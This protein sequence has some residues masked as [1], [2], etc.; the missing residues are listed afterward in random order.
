MYSLSWILNT[1]WKSVAMVCSCTPRRRS[2]AIAK[3][4]FPTIAITADPLYSK[5]CRG[6]GSK[7]RQEFEIQREGRKAR[8]ARWSG[9]LTDMA[10]AAARSRRVWIGA[11]VSTRGAEQGGSRDGAGLFDGE[12]ELGFLVSKKVRRRRSRPS[13]T[14]VWVRFVLGVYSS[15]PSRLLTVSLKFKLSNSTSF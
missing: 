5:I 8:V 3:Q 13:P 12:A 11:S 2:L 14:S 6:R 4:F 15:D 1:R 7:T 9:V 10:G